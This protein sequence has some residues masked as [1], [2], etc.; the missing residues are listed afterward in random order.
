M[1]TATNTLRQTAPAQARNSKTGFDLFLKQDAIANR[2]NQVVS[3]KEEGTKFISSLM[4]AVTTTPTIQECTPMSILNCGLQ[5]LALNLSPLPALGQFH[6]LPF[7]N[8]NDN[9]VIATPVIGY[10]GYIQLAI[11]SGY[12][13]DI[14]ALAVKE[15]ELIKWDAFENKFEAVMIEDEKERS[16][17]KTVG[18]YVRFEYLNGFKKQM[19][20]S[21]DKMQAHALNYSSAYK[22]DV[23]KKVALSPWSTD[24]DGMANKTMLRQ[25]LGTWGILSTEMQQAFEMEHETAEKTAFVETT[26]S[27]VEDS[28]FDE[29]NVTDVTPNKGE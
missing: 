20:W 10:K 29:A 25:L 27:E 5:A 24:F 23:A 18:Y 2:I 16:E 7:K 21:V 1:K 8:N 14:D 3:S 15:G 22:N 4:S 28:F 13:K 17:K 6:F 26:V 11:R 12:Y 19:Y 9:T